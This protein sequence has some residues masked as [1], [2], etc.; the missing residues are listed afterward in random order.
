MELD[1]AINDRRSIRA[2]EETKVEKNIIEKILDSGIKS[3]SANN[4]QPW[5]FIV[6]NDDL[7]NQIANITES[8]IVKQVGT[9]VLVYSN[10]PINSLMDMISVGACIEN[11]LLTAT[12]FGLGTLWVGSLVAYEKEISELL[13]IKDLNLISGI[14]IGYKKEDPQARP[15]KTMDEVVE[16]R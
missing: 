10:A 6:L 4:K 5:K 14:A 8:P 2:F 12:E 16:W 11:M 3:P 15:R 13:N 9:M 7:K 1:N